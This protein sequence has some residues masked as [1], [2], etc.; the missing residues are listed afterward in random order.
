MAF[1][2]A[3]IRSVQDEGTHYTVDHKDHGRFPVAKKG[4]SKET[5]ARIQKL[6]KGGEVMMAT[7]GDVPDVAP[8]EPDDE[9]GDSGSLF[10]GA[11]PD[12][13]RSHI[14]ITPPD[15][16]GTFPAFASKPPPAPAGTGTVLAPQPSP[17]GVPATEDLVSVP[18]GGASEGAP[19]ETAPAAV[20]PAEPAKPAAAAP[21]VAVPG[22]GDMGAIDAATKQEIAAEQERQ[23]IEG[24]RQKQAAE[25]QDASNQRQQQLFNEAQERYK[26]VT[27]NQEGL[28]NDIA[29][30]KIDASRWWDSRST[31]QKVSATIGMILGGIGAGMTGG[32]NQALDIIQNSIS[33]DIDAQKA[34]LGKK[35]SLLS[36]YVQQGHDI[37]DAMKLA[38][39]H[40]LAAVEGQMRAATA[41]YSALETAPAA[42]S[43]T[44][45]LKLKGVQMRHEV[46]TR[47]LDNAVKREQLMAAQIQRAAMGDQVAMMPVMRE[48]NSQLSLGKGVDPRFGQFMDPKTTVKLDDGK[49]YQANTEKD[50]DAI[51]D[52]QEAAAKLKSVA[53]R[54]KTFRQSHSGGVVLG[55]TAAAGEGASL[56]QEAEAAIAE[57]STKLRLNSDSRAQL[58][59]I[60]VNPADESTTDDR[61]NG[62]MNALVERAQRFIGASIRTR[63]RNGGGAGGGHPLK[64]E[65]ND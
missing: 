54:I 6:C 45:Q 49:L 19:Q 13:I 8:I 23:R 55:G 34:N 15:W 42:Q 30:G 38:A 1:D 39:A 61:V 21:P 43:I 20:P 60:I 10:G 56:Q 57:L 46:A 24:E 64:L 65:R 33:R 44:A 29:N 4:L 40:E 50:A 59:K 28:A 3:K 32:P 52:G 37:Q 26:A 2:L 22:A 18:S 58:E 7:G 62:Q 17:P 63:I 35:Q 14:E 5:D 27:A 41:R 12:W 25:L 31:G 53:A 47:S 51:K 48:L 36:A 9:G 11:V 16:K